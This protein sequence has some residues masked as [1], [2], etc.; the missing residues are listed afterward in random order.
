MW[1]SVKI[2]AITQI[3]NLFLD[4]VLTLVPLLIL[5]GV[6]MEKGGWTITNPMAFFASAAADFIAKP[7]QQKEPLFQMYKKGHVRTVDGSKKVE[8]PVQPLKVYNGVTQLLPWMQQAGLP[9]SL[10]HLF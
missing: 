2:T 6:L 5:R 8:G 4:P 9:C 1:Q 7:S 10:F 3:G